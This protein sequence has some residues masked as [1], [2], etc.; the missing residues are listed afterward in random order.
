MCLKRYTVVTNSEHALPKTWSLHFLPKFLSL[1]SGELYS[2][3]RNGHLLRKMTPD[4]ARRQN[5][6]L[7]LRST[8]RDWWVPFSRALPRWWERGMRRELQLFGLGGFAEVA[9]GPC[10]RQR[11]PPGC[12]PAEQLE[13]ELLEILTTVSQHLTGVQVPVLRKHEWNTNP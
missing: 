9:Q 6:S 1:I 8:A 13:M 11:W 10:W 5:L 7:C 2:V 4:A 3:Y 12:P